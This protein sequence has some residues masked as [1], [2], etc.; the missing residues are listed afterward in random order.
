[1]QKTIQ[2]EQPTVT[3]HGSIADHT[4]FRCETGD[5]TADMPKDFR[6]FPVDKFGEC[7]SGH[8]S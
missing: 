1:M 2:F 3:D 5:E 8:A 7:S 6:V 4:F